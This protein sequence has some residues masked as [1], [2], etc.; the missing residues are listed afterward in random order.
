MRELAIKSDS[1][2]VLNKIVNKKDD[3]ILNQTQNIEL[4]DSIITNYKNIVGEK[5]IQL[6]SYKKEVKKQ[7]TQKFVAWGITATTIIFSIVRIL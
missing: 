7:K 3:I 1:I 6:S 4:K 2:S 5:E